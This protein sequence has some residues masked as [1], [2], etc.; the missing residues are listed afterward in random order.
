MVGQPQ[1][2]IEE[3][4]VGLLS[5]FLESL[6][7]LVA[8]LEQ[9]QRLRVLGHQHITHV[10]GE[11]LDEQSTVEAL[12]DDRVE[13]YHNVAHLIF[14]REVYDA[15]VVLRVE[16]VEILDDLLVGDVALT[17]RGSLI[18]DGE[19]VAHTTVGLLGNDGECLFL[20]GDAL[21]VG[22]V[23]QVVDGVAD[24]H[25]LEVVDLASREDGGQD[26]VLLGG[27]EDEDDVSGRLLKRF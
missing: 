6:A 22:H 2:L 5:L 9:G 3:P 12:V 21:L 23:L 11:T 20:V 8:H 18:E 13:Q 15:E 1:G 7:L 17:E 10:A 24:G 19:G 14:Y 26:L 27:G 16:H 25:P 4:C